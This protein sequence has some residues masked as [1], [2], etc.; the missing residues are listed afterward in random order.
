MFVA[1]FLREVKP[2]GS[3]PARG[4]VRAAVEGEFRAGLE[5]GVVGEL[6]T[7]GHRNQTRSKK[8]REKLSEHI[9]DHFQHKSFLFV[10]VRLWESPEKSMKKKEKAVSVAETTDFREKIVFGEYLDYDEAEG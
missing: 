10:N 2:V 7:Q 3:S 6:L 9:N 1:G 5:M 8:I 4:A